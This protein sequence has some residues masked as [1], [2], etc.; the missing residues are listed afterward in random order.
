ETLELQ[1]REQLY[2]KDRPPLELGGRTVILVDDGLATGS[3][4]RAAVAALRMHRPRWVAVGVPIASP[5]TCEELREEVDDIVCA[6]TPQEFRAVG[7]WYEDFS[8]TTNEEIEELLESAAREP[9]LNWNRASGS[10]VFGRRA[11]A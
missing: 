2:R 9:S 11:P 4:M 1:R 3:T 10:L 5:S 6:I 7:P 8:Q